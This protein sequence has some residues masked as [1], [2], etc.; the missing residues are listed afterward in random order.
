MVRRPRWHVRRTWRSKKPP[1]VFLY[2]FL[3]RYFY[4]FIHGFPSFWKKKKSLKIF[5][6][7]FKILAFLD[8]CWVILIFNCCCAG[9]QLDTNKKAM[10]IQVVSLHVLGFHFLFFVPTHNSYYFFCLICYFSYVICGYF[11]FIYQKAKV[12]TIFIF[13]YPIIIGGNRNT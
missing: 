6:Y 13:L 1:R 12:L 3:S 5:P 11:D 9:S 4:H 10:T 7:Y 2:F 8:R